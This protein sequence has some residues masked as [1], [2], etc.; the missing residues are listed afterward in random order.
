MAPD[1]IDGLSRIMQAL[2]QRLEAQQPRSRRAGS[3]A[4]SSGTAGGAGARPGAGIDQVKKQL[5]SRIR[6]LDPVDRGGPAGMRIFVEAILTWEFGE[7]MLNDPRFDELS[8]EV[9][10]QLSADPAIGVRLK[11]LLERL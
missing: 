1:S 2:Q 4:K 6:A 11:R 8:R 5:G 10:S 9:Q 3:P 7:Q